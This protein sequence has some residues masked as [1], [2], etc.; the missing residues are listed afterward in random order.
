MQPSEG[1]IYRLLSRHILGNLCFVT[2]WACMDKRDTYLHSGVKLSRKNEEM[3]YDPEEFVRF[4][5]KIAY[6]YK[7][8]GF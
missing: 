4:T 2:E 3:N 8:E 6:Y 5:F 7:R 1:K